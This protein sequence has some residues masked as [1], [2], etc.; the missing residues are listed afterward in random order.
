MSKDNEQD[1][2]SRPPLSLTSFLAALGRGPPVV[3]LESKGSGVVVI[4]PAR[5]PKT[6]RNRRRWR[7]KRHGVLGPRAVPL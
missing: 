5:Q 3:A 4:R 2:G 6:K 7:R 1:G